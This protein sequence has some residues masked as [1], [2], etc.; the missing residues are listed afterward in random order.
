MGVFTKKVN[1]WT[2]T[3]TVESYGGIRR[4]LSWVE[5]EYK[6]QQLLD[7]LQLKYNISHYF[8]KKSEKEINS[9]KINAGNVNKIN[10]II[11]KHLDARD[12]AINEFDTESS[13]GNNAEALNKWKEKLRQNEI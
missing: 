2:G 7:Y 1:V 6:S 5:P 4:D 9:G 11:E 3:I 12:K 8:A 10:A 13:F